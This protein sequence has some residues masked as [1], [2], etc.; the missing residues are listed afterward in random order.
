DVKSASLLWSHH[1]PKD[2]PDLFSGEGVLILYWPVSAST[3]KAAINADPAL[4]ARLK[5]MKEKE[6]DY[7][8][9]VWDARSGN[10]RG[11]LLVET[12]KGAFRVNQ[13]F[14]AGDWMVLTDNTNRVL[15]YSLSSG[16]LHGRVFGNRA[17]VSRAAG[18]LAVENERGVLALYDLTSLE[19]RAEHIFS[20]PLSLAA[21]SP[22]GTRLLVVTA[23]QTAYVL[24]VA[25]PAAA[26]QSR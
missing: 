16:E 8:L 19:K 15:L 18:L 20:A 26:S 6:G 4:K 24:E 22:D 2:A 13:A 25:A 12:S 11:R 3:A 5:E 21:F 23:G 7:Y 14:A 1:F 10:V 17:T 9:E